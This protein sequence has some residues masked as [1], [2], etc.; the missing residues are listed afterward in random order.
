[1]MLRSSTLYVEH[2]P[3][4]RLRDP[5]RKCSVPSKA[6]LSKVVRLFK[7]RQISTP[8][9]EIMT[10]KQEHFRLLSNLSSQTNLT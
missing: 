8:A 1:M 3:V 4:K 10:P 9:T 2:R 7:A 5:A 6:R